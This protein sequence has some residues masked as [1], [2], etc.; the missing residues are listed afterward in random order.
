MPSVEP[1]VS[2]GL[3]FVG[4]HVLVEGVVDGVGEGQLV[5]ALVVVVGSLAENLD[6]GLVGH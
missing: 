3:F 5:D 1:G 6:L 2:L 4:E